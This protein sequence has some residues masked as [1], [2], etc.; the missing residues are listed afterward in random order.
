MVYLAW[1]NVKIHEV[2]QLMTPNCE[3]QMTNVKYAYVTGNTKIDS[4]TYGRTIF[5]IIVQKSTFNKFCLQSFCQKINH[6]DFM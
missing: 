1:K 2:Y 4:V 3:L 6:V 5:A